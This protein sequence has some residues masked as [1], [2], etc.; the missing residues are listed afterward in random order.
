MRIVVAIVLALLLPI[1]AYAQPAPHPFA[2]FT[3][4]QKTYEELRKALGQLRFDDVVQ[5]IIYLETLE[6]TAQQQAATAKAAPE[7]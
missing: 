3:V 4:D 6:R 1:T 5:V 7:K 2:P